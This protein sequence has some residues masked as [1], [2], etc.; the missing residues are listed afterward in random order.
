MTSHHTMAFTRMYFIAY[1]AQNNLCNEL[2]RPDPDLRRLVGH[3]NLLDDLNDRMM[4]AKESENADDDEGIVIAELDGTPV[5]V[6]EAEFKHASTKTS[7]IKDTDEKKPP[8][9]QKKKGS[10]PTVAAIEVVVEMEKDDWPSIE[11]VP[12]SFDTAIHPKP[13]HGDV[14]FNLFESVLPALSIL[15]LDDDDGYESDVDLAGIIRPA[16]GVHTARLACCYGLAR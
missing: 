5:E 14:E 10:V 4:A 6:E 3:G 7:A 13:Q 2:D 8:G 12:M 9:I 1:R 15:Y 11:G 16:T